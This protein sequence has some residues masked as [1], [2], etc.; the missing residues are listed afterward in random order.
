MPLGARPARSGEARSQITI[1]TP[2]R[3][4]PL[5][6][7]LAVRAPAWFGRLPAPVRRLPPSSPLRRLVL[8]RAA[9]LIYEALNRGQVD[10]LAARC[11]PEVEIRIAGAETGLDLERAY[12]GREG[13]ARLNDKWWEAWEEFRWEPVELIDFGDRLVILARQIGRGRGSGAEVELAHASVVTFDQGWVVRIQFYW[14]W[15]EAERTARVNSGV[16]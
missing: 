3:H 5:D 4:R 6:A 7:W 1:R 9:R 8:V 13:L 10:V 15:D 11:Y 2:S 16:A 14:D 12:R